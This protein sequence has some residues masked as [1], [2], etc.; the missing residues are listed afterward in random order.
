M[1]WQARLISSTTSA[2]NSVK[3]QDMTPFPWPSPRN[4]SGGVDAYIAQIRADARDVSAARTTDIS[5]TTWDGSPFF[6]AAG[7]VKQTGLVVAIPQ[8]QVPLISNPEFIKA[9]EEAEEEY[10]TVIEVVPVG[11]W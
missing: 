11:E 10:N 4:L 9:M 5:G 2:D 1:L 8:S 7:K 6:L 3:S